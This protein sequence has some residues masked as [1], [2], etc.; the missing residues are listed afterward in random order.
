VEVEENV[1]GGE[2]AI[3]SLYIHLLFINESLIDGWLGMKS[4]L[5]KIT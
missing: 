3:K 1:E 5:V 2:F 4:T